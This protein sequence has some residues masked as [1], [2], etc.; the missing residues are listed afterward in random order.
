MADPM[1][2]VI[3]LL[4]GILGSVLERGGKPIWDVSKLG[5]LQQLF[6]GGKTLSDG[7]DPT[8]HSPGDVIRATRLINDVHM[9]PGLWKIDGYTAI[10]KAIQSKFAVTPG[11][12]YFEFPYDW[13]SDNRL[14]AALLKEKAQGWLGTFRK[15]SPNAKLVLV[16]HS[17]GGLVSRYFL[18]VMGG[19]KD[20]RSL[21]TFGTPYRGSLKALEFLANGL[22]KGFGPL[23]LLD[24]TKAIQSTTSVYQ[25]LPSF[26]CYDPGD[27]KLRRVNEIAIPGLDP[28]RAAEGLDF[29]NEITKKQEANAKLADYREGGYRVYPITGIEQPTAQSAK[30]AGDRIETLFTIS[31]EDPGGDGT[32]PYPS[33]LPREWPNGDKRHVFVST[34]HASIQNAKPV[35]VQLGG[36]LRTVD[37]SKW[38]STTGVSGLERISL[39]VP[40]FSDPTSDVVVRVR[41]PAEYELS[42][43][44]HDAADDQLVRRTQIAGSKDWKACAFDPLPQ[45]VYRITVDGGP[46]TQAATDVFA[47][48]A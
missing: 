44:V 1:N 43:S 31:G 27:G 21:V 8:Q 48:M 2:D 3:V 4:P 22:H 38:L 7:L 34:P 5:L 37:F 12:N 33:A 41:C 6:T 18:E 9:V 35:L 16:A 11:D 36:I 25:M 26:R 47:V 10:S 32:V 46:E 19:W 20:T 15:K 28:D 13:T 39:D 23:T 24:L 42:V 30:L 14:S 45:G 40:D 17:M 29:Q